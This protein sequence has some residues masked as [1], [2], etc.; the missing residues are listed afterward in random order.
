[1]A[2]DPNKK[3]EEAKKKLEEVTSVVDAISEGFKDLTDRF[4]EVVNEIKDGAVEL[5][6]FNNITNSVKKSIRE[7]N[8]ING[9]LIKNQIALN[10]KTLTTKDIDEQ[11]NKIKSTRTVLES[12]LA[13]LQEKIAKDGSAT[14]EQ[15][16]EI[17]HLNKLIAEQSQEIEDHLKGQREEAKKLEESLNN[18]NQSLGIAG[19]LLKGAEGLL[20]KMG[21][22]A[23]NNVINFKQINKELQ[24]QAEVLTNNGQTVLG[25]GGKFKLAANAAFLFGK[26]LLKAF[27]DPTV[28]IGLLIK[29]FQ[30]LVELGFRA[31][32][33]VTNLSKS[34]AVSKNV[35]TILRDRFVEIEQSGENIFFTSKNLVEAQ[36]ELADAFKATRGFT[37]QQVKDQVYLTK[38]IGLSAE[39]AAS[40]QQL[41]MANGKNANDIIK[42]TIK[43]TAALAKQTGVQLDNK[44]ILGEVAKV[45]G[46][47][48]LQYQNN[49]DLIAKAVVQTQKLGISLEYAKKMAEG[50]LDFESSITNELSAELITGKDL[51]LERARLLALNGKSAEA[52]AEMLNQIKGS[53]E[54]SKMN[55]IQQESLAKAVGMT[56][57]ELANSLV[58][59]ENLNRLG[60]ETKKQIQAQAEELR[61]KGKVDEANQLLNSLGNEKQA[62]AALD[63]IAAQ[64]K[65][66]QSMEILQRMVGDLVAGPMG[67]FLDKLV[68]FVSKAENLQKIFTT[69][70]VIM[71]GL[72]A[73]SA[74]MAV[75]WAVMNPVAAIAGLAIGG[76]IGGAV[77]AAMGD[78]IISEGYGNRT[79]LTPKG[80]VA[81]NN[82]DT[83]IAGTN[84]FRGDDVISSP[85]GSIN[86]GG[87]GGDMSVLAQKMDRMTNILTQ[88]LN[89]E[90][91]VY[92]DTTK[93]GTATT[94]GT[95]KTQ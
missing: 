18:I 69:I 92:M 62:K 34:M 19:N 31:D 43:Q 38:Q 13:N 29:G 93:V 28:V 83:V 95:Y 78:D 81:L 36:L 22:G 80:A 89:K 49:P 90:G 26:Q 46:Q 37:E 76:M 57:D 63:N 55:V 85:K 23:L 3:A 50:L 79:L 60:S 56:A 47:L 70:K 84:L 9:D 1:M 8:K 53:A 74:A 91:A 75:A 44:K 94:V 11:I 65:F 20:K 42:S 5:N 72:V 64:D 45:S 66:N 71:A 54:F 12:R 6:Y 88:I 52:A 82:Q 17:T 86:L 10:N 48:R 15:T 67:Q 58:Q 59:Q 27:L 41:A 40:L 21:L 33:E 35:A 2:D 73:A 24:Q 39:E 14:L 77:Y 87:S 30:K 68:T 61:K 51:N 25:F 32:R 7:L 16:K 4:S